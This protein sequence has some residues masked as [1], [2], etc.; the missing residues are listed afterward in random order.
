M[1]GNIH[2]HRSIGLNHVLHRLH[3]YCHLMNGFEADLTD[4]YLEDYYR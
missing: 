3:D 4:D 2:Y 1:I